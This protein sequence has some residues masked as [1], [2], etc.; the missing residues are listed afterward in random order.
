MPSVTIYK[1]EIVVPS[2]HPDIRVINRGLS[3]ANTWVY[4]LDIGESKPALYEAHTEG[5]WTYWRALSYT[6]FTGFHNQRQV[7]AVY[8]SLVED[9]EFE[10]LVRIV[11][12]AKYF[13]GHIGRLA[14]WREMADQWLFQVDFDLPSMDWNPDGS[15]AIE[16]VHLQCWCPVRSLEVVSM[17]DIRN[18]SERTSET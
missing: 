14:G 7:E 4:T 11:G 12:N 17:I 6:D 1:N 2:P 18:K 16:L 3:S 10:T 9:E 8:R 5:D 13:H 15:P